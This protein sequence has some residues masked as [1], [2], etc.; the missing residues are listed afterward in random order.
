MHFLDLVNWLNGSPW[1]VWMRENDYFFASIETIHIL[2]LG[3]SVG[4]IMWIDLRLISI[5]MNRYRVK[6]IVGQIEK[7]AIGGFSVMFVSGLL[8]L[9]SEPLKCYSTFAFRLKVLMLP[10][11][12]LNVLY[13]HSKGVFGSV[14][15]WD[16]EAKAP[17]RARMVAIV[18][19]LL[20][21]GIIIA[22]RWTAYTS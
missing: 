14:S 15:E 4:I 17:W 1:S 21:F 18:S 11:A 9:F 20:W 19:L 12:G 8:L 2:A 10:L 3:F 22:G 6:E 5:S 13:F 7:L 16:D